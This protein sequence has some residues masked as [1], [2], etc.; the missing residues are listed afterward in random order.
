MHHKEFGLVPRPG[1][2]SSVTWHSM[3][4]KHSTGLIS[5]IAHCEKNKN[6]NY[7]CSSPKF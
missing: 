4:K 3:P 6:T 5:H 2:L 7:T 1:F